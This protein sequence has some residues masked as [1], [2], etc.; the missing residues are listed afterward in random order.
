[1]SEPR[2]SIDLEHECVWFLVGL[3]GSCAFRYMEERSTWWWSEHKRREMAEG[4]NEYQLA[5]LIAR[6]Q[7]IDEGLIKDE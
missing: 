1:M 5:F 3:E 2:Y 6:D 4:G 7:L